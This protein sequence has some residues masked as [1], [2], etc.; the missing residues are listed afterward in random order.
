MKDTIIKANQKRRELIILIISF[1]AAFLFNIYSIIRYSHPFKEVFTQI[2]IVV[3]ITLVFY[4]IITILRL[5]WWLFTL[6]YIRFT[7]SR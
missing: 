3:L 6:I 7:K 5:I 2:H 1:I 4:V